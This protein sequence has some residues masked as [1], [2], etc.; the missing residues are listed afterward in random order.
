MAKTKKARKGLEAE[1][2][3]LRR[4][5]TAA[6]T[7]SVLNNLIRWGALS[8]FAYMGFRALEVMAGKTTIANIRIVANVIGDS[9][10]S[11]V[12]AWLLATVG[13]GYGVLQRALKQ[14]AIERLGPQRKAYEEQLDPGR[15]SSRLTRQ[16]R[17]PRERDE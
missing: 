4:F 16:G 2:L 6:G 10:V 15:T 1:N 8:W 7:A 3:L 13:I 5:R 12:L 11:E 9:F 17:T 14:K